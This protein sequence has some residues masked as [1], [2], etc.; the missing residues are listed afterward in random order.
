MIAELRNIVAQIRT[1]ENA[2]EDFMTKAEQVKED[3]IRLN[4]EIEELR[5]KLKEQNIAQENPS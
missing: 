4:K 3:N 1:F 2:V 5:N